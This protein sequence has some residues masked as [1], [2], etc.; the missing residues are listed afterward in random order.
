MDADSWKVDAKVPTPFGDPGHGAEPPDSL[1]GARA[2]PAPASPGDRAPHSAPV[3]VH[4][5]LVLVQPSKLRANVNESALCV[6]VV[7]THFRSLLTHTCDRAIAVARACAAAVGHLDTVPA[8][9]RVHFRSIHVLRT[10]PHLAP[11]TEPS[12]TRTEPSG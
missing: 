7:L 2:R 4:C 3:L 8:N 12:G 5:A 11:R 9:G 6:F 1:C 10:L